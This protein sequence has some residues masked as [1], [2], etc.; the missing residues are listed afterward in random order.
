M[1]PIGTGSLEDEHSAAP[2]EVSGV[3]DHIEIEAVYAKHSF[4]DRLFYLKI[5]TENNAETIPTAPNNS[6]A[7]V[8]H[9]TSADSTESEKTLQWLL[10]VAC[11]LQSRMRL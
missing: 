1:G 6:V 9:N 10:N 2:S 7:P 11:Y 5:I 8:E 3:L 4:Y